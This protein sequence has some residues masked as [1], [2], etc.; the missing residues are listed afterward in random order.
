MRS[1]KSTTNLYGIRGLITLTE[2][3][4]PFWYSESQCRAKGFRVLKLPADRMLH[5]WIGPD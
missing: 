1:F 5:L 3:D 2:P 4:S